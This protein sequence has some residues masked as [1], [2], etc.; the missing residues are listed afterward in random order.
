MDI[1]NALA[2]LLDDADVPPKELVL[3]A[4]YNNP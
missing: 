4:L 2:D 1:A 3:E